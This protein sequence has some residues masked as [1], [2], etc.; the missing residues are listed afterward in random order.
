VIQRVVVGGG[1]DAAPPFPDL[2][3]GV[4][5]TR[6]RAGPQAS[7]WETLQGCSM[8]QAAAWA[9]HMLSMSTCAC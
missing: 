3:R 2:G 4:G 5:H 7:S 1:G 6:V 8:V 9:S